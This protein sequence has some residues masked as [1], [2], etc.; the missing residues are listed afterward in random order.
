MD[1]REKEK[2]MRHIF[3][4]VL[5]LLITGSQISHAQQPSSRSDIV[6][7]ERAGLPIP[8]KPEDLRLI[9]VEIW[10]RTR[11]TNQRLYSFAREAAQFRG[12]YNICRRHELNVDIEPI[13]ALAMRNLQQILLAHYEEPE[14][15]VLEAMPEEAQGPFVLDLAGDLYAFEYG[16][17]S[18]T[19]LDAIAKSG[20]TRQ[21]FCKRIAE[22]NYNKYI[23]LRATTKREGY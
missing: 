2:M 17:A 7:D 9:T 14:L 5:V 6:I 19:I 10:Q 18:T 20:D 8:E 3:L 21:T 22:E 23:A 15:A 16:S 11:Q 13:N 12:Y 1:G 4:S